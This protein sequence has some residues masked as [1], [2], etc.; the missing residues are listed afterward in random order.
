[1]RRRSVFTLIAA[2]LLAPLPAGALYFEYPDAELV[3]DLPI[4]WQLSESSDG[5]SVADSA[6]RFER[7]DIRAEL[8]VSRADGVS[9]DEAIDR[10]AT[11]LGAA[12]DVAVFDYAGEEAFF[13]DVELDGGRSG[14]LMTV[15]VDGRIAVLFVTAPQE[16]RPNTEEELLSVADSLF[17]VEPVQGPVSV[18][19]EGTVS[20][21]E[22]IEIG[23]PGPHGRGLPEDEAS[24][25]FAAGPDAVETGNVLISREATILERYEF[26]DFSRGEGST[27]APA[28]EADPQWLR[29]WRRYFRL[30]YRDSHPRVEQLAEEIDALF[31]SNGIAGRE[32][33]DVLLSWLQAFEFR[34]APNP[35]LFQTTAE[36]LMSASGDCDSLAVIYVAL[37][38][39]LGIDARLLVSTEYGHAIAI[40]DSADGRGGDGETN[41]EPK[42]TA[43]PAGSPETGRFELEGQEFL[44]AE[45]TAAWPLGTIAAG[46]AD[47]AGWHVVDVR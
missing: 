26:R 17:P 35:G 16:V 40:V 13:S 43:S 15:E 46:H 31:D 1:M 47:A 3:L 24:V 44:P 8:F 27:L 2:I 37:L 29:A 4:G 42:G 21:T 6:W 12:G 9:I 11:E 41:G 25:T 36:S 19:F 22:E 38:D 18:F 33:A 30:I 14:Y 10:A 23:F 7:G 28:G 5:G 45:M 20:D 39:H 32:R 34:Q